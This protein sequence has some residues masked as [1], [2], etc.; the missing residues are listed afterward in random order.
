MECLGHV[1]AQSGR[2]PEGLALLQK[3]VKTIESMGSFQFATLGIVHL[4]EAYLLVNRLE[5]AQASA[6][7]ALA[8]IREGGQR[9]YEAYAL[10]LLGEIASHRDYRV[11]LNGIDAPESGQPFGNRAK[12]LPRASPS[13]RWSPSGS[14]TAT[15]TAGS[16]RT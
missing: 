10:R 12:Q 5:D 4:G 9:G 11:R 1:Y 6:A 8:L 3:A 7:K 13:E 14:R 16:S 2:V 15:A